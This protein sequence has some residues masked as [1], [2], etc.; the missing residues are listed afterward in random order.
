ML[1]KIFRFA[2]VITVATVAV[3]TSI[4]AQSVSAQ[5]KSA[6]V[7]V[8]S[9]NN[10]QTDISKVAALIDP[11]F[12]ILVQMAL[13][14]GTNFGLDMTKPIALY[15]IPAEAEMG[16]VT[17]VPLKSPKMFEAQMANL[18]ESGTIPE[19]VQIE[20]KGDYVVI[21]NG[22]TWD[23]DV[24]EITADGL[25]HLNTKPG[26]LSPILEKVAALTQGENGEKI[27][28][29]QKEWAQIDNFDLTLNITEDG[30]IKVDTVVTP[31]A[32]TEIGKLYVACEKLTKSTLGPL[33]DAE[34]PMSGQFLSVIGQY[35]KMAENLSAREDIP[36]EIRDV[37]L[38]ALQVEK[39]DSAFSFY[40]DDKGIYGIYAMGIS[41]SAEI[42]ATLVKALEDGKVNGKANADKI[43]KSI[44]IH[45]IELEGAN[46]ALGFHPKYLFVTISA[47]GSDPVN[48][49]KKMFKERTPKVGKVAQNGTISFDMS[50]L[51][52]YFPQVSDL[53]GKFT[54][55]AKFENG[56][57]ITNWTIESAL[58]LSAGKIYAT[59]KNAAGEEDGNLGE[60]EDVD[61]DELFGDEE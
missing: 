25:I 21:T 10:L 19:S 11:N 49:M 30:S 41:N 18:R 29:V 57:Y 17:F 33:C 9:L 42:S 51:A 53:T 55:L 36:E 58:I 50:L 14:Q 45:E 59:Y 12:P 16:L 54:S 46:L 31:K 37:I 35:E 24:P 3:M 22:T 23:A 5:E 1:K 47:N 28:A 38:K 61:V 2:T 20:V 4:T 8:S 15:G 44:T 56:T 6:T 60:D 48:L 52:P 27:Q 34:A 7:T 32:D 43:G 26:E 13:A 39:F 40:S